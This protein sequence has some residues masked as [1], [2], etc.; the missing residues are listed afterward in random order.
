MT[1][2]FANDEGGFT[3]LVVF[4]NQLKE[5]DLPLVVNEKGLLTQNLEI[6]FRQSRAEYFCD[7]NRI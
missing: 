3:V 6:E 4:E 1:E 2:A 5:L 7:W